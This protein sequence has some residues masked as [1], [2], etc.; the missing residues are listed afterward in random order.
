MR[1]MTT[2]WGEGDRVA[3]MLH[4][5]MSCAD[6]FW[7][8]GPVLAD[9]G[10]RVVAVDLPG[11]GNSAAVRTADLALFASS[12]VETIGSHPELALGHS[13]GGVV[14]AEALPDLRPSR[15]VYVDVP[16]TAATPAR[17]P[18]S[19]D[20]A[21]TLTARF[22]PAREG[23]TVE[24][25][26]I[27]RPTWSDKDRLVEA[28]AA[29]HFDVATAVALELAHA[30]NPPT[31]PPSAEIPSLVI[32]ADPSRFVSRKRADELRELGFEVRSIHGAGHSIWYGHFTEFM[33]ALDGW[34]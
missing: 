30:R 25:L 29:R 5:M 22:A 33:A 4:S 7:R 15:A 23:R 16:L 6:Q 31:R 10:Y 17:D 11:H 27:S 34:V 1:L 14:L 8:V 20:D 9:R 18:E 26:R 19:P 2:Q 32:R 3:L 12:V 21:K 24:A 13:L 28:R